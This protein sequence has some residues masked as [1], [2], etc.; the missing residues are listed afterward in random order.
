MPSHSRFCE[1]DGLCPSGVS[2]P[3]RGAGVS[4]CVLG[5]S[6]CVLG[7]LVWPSVPSASVSQDCTAA[8]FLLPVI[9]IGLLPAVAHHDGSC[10]QCFCAS[11][12]VGVGPHCS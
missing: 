2:G 3:S 8:C 12:F 7:V 5:V 1:S 9:D 11:L 10:R 6:W 4:W